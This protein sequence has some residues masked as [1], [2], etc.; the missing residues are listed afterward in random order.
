MRIIALAATALAVQAIPQYYLGIRVG[1][2]T[3][4]AAA[5]GI[6]Q[7]PHAKSLNHIFNHVMGAPSPIR[8]RPTPPDQYS[9]STF[10]GLPVTD[11]W[12]RPQGALFITVEG[13]GD[14]R[15]HGAPCA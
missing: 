9:G 2:A 11:I 14:C 7:D 8:F 4:P 15:R 10:P 3:L 1:Y 13:A 6:E 12:H 5:T